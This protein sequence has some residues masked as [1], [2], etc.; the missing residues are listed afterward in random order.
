V[1]PVNQAVPPLNLEQM[2]GGQDSNHPNLQLQTV[3][4]DPTLGGSAAGATIAYVARTNSN[5]TLGMSAGPQPATPMVHTTSHAALFKAG[6]IAAQQ[7]E[8]SA[9]DLG[10]PPLGVAATQ[11]TL[12]PLSIFANP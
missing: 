3:H 5:A 6:T 8:I 4:S 11:K 12:N 9:D 2:Q 1:R 10:V 7:R